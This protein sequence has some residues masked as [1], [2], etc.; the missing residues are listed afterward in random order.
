MMW[1]KPFLN[2]LWRVLYIAASF[3]LLNGV[4]FSKSQSV[5]IIIAIYF[6]TAAVTEE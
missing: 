2:F 6:I 4:G 1:L 3:S 5:T